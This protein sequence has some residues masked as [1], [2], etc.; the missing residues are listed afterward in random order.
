MSTAVLIDGGF[1][2][3]RFNRLSNNPRKNDPSYVAKAIHTMAFKHTEM[4]HGKIDKL[5]RIFYYDCRP[6]AGHAQNPINNSIIDFANAPVAQFRNALHYELRKKRKIALRLGYLKSSNQWSFSPRDTSDL[7]AGEK[8]LSDI[9]PEHLRYDLKQKGIDIKIGVDIT[10]LALKRLVD[11]IVLV[12][13]DGDFVPAAKTA[14]REGIDFILDPMWSRIDDSLHEHIDGLSS[15]F[16][17]RDNRFEGAA[18][19]DSRQSAFNNAKYSDDEE[20]EYDDD[21]YDDDD[22]SPQPDSN[23]SPRRW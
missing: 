1:F 14:R 12:S 3:K 6:F 10:W 22:N 8:K 18:P 9:H 15:P 7:L 19:N 21:E 16:F 4:E 11:R 13:G 17:G 23:E 2:I 20:A 5:Y